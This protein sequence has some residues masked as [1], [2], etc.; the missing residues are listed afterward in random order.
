MRAA[1]A[2][3]LRGRDDAL[4]RLAGRGAAPVVLLTGE[5]GVGKTRLAAEAAARAA[6]G[7]AAVLWGAGQ[8]PDG[9]TPYGMF[10]EALD[11]W[12]AGCDAAE[13]A[14]IGAEYPELAVLLP[15]L[16]QV[17]GAGEHTPEE[18]RDRLFRAG[19]LVLG[20]LAVEQ[21]VLVVL[22]DLQAGDLGTFRLL[23]HLARHAAELRTDLRFLATYRA[24][25]LHD[26]DPRRAVVASLARQGLCATERLDGLDEEACLAMV[27]D[28]MPPAERAEGAHR[29]AWRLSRGNPLFALELARGPLGD[30]GAGDGADGGAA[31]PDGVAQ[32]VAARLDR[33][34]PDA[35]RV[36]EA[37]AVVGGEAALTE[38][39]DVARHGLEPPVAGAAAADAVER[40]I[41]A[42]LVEERQVVVSGRGEDGLAFRHPVV[43]LTCYERLSAVR[44]R[45]LH[46]AVAGAVLR[47]R[48]DAVDTL[49]SHLA[50]ADDPRAAEYLRRAAERAAA[51]YANDAADRY[52]RDLVNR[53][54]VDAARARLAHSGVLFRMGQFAAASATLRTALAE[55]VRRDEAAESVL[56]AGRLAQCLLRTGEVDEAARVLRA[57][58]VTARTPPE[59]EA[60]HRLAL[61]G[62]RRAQGR[63]DEGHDAAR[64]ALAAA[65]EVP[66][67]ERH[68]LVARAYAGQASNLGLAG[69]FA[70]S[71]EAADRALAPAEAYGDPTLLGAVLSTLRENARRS[72]RL[73]RAVEFGER[74]L[75]LAL[76]SGDQTSAAFERANLAELRLL[77]DEP[78]A[79]RD[80]AE[81][82]FAAAE[83]ERTW[84]LPY[85]LAA[86]ASVRGR[87]GEHDDAAAL[88]D[89]AETVVATAGDR[90][91]RLVVRLARAE[92]H[93]AAADP[94]AA[95]EILG[96]GSDGVTG[97]VLVAWAHL[98]AGRPEEARRVAAAEAERAR[99]AGEHL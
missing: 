24:E 52:Y 87:A 13:R 61:S 18:E 51:L 83:W 28:A 56:V 5:A 96:D 25:E 6:A 31:A 43:R 32:A 38:L 97:A 64:R 48:P 98:A 58:P 34:D 65:R 86:L 37:L 42:S 89:R 79:A 7:G 69:R 10:A 12:F 20:A 3:P 21:P 90:Q 40:A 45:Q 71:R 8:D 27:R 26:A 2:A 22:D 80:L 41:A 50:R 68:G 9:R 66:G 46:A 1:A 74:A 76:R 23:G 53:L 73:A 57:H 33:L 36:V 35:R 30:G 14:E 75:E 59:A 82:A 60:Q 67:A 19:A 29:R 55:F 16:G 84:C 92:H 47:R 4:G 70:E 99:A 72:G 54:D 15:S 94:A 93:L 85:A 17:P 78:D 88:L 39:L 11:R 49:A 77:L 95:L 62:V 91:A 63:H 44:R 81:Q